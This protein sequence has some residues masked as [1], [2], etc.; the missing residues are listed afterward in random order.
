MVY[1]T[2]KVTDESNTMYPNSFRGIN[3]FFFKKLI[4]TNV[5]KILKY[6]TLS[7]VIQVKISENAIFKVFIQVNNPKS[8]AFTTLS[9]NI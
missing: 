3:F 8:F 1:S 7:S 9:I 4:V 5:L 2:D 6:D